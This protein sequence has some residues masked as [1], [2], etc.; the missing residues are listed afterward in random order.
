MLGIL[1]EDRRDVLRWSEDMLGTQGVDDE[2]LITRQMAAG[3]A[4]H[5]YASRVV[6]ERR[7]KP[8]DDLISILVNA[9]IDGERLTDEDVIGETL[10]ILIGGDETT[11]HVIAGGVEQLLRNPQHWQALLADRSRIPQTVEE[12]LRW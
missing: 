4:Y 1:P 12:M 3:I 6:T 2:D 8:A 7:A 5:E 9:E 11:R 10:L